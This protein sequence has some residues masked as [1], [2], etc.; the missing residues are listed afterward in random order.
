[1]SGPYALP[2][3][4]ALLC[5][6]AAARHRSFK[7]AAGELSVTPAAVSHQIRALESDLGRALFHRR[8]RGVELTEA[9][10]MLFL[11]LQ[12]SFEDISDTV[13]ALRGRPEGA[14]VSIE[15]TTAM[16]AYWL[17]PQIGAFW[18]EHPQIAISQLVSD[19]PGPGARA[20][21]AIRY[22]PP[23]RDEDRAW[24]LFHDR[25]VAVGSPGFAR[26][27]GFDR[28][29]AFGTAARSAQTDGGTPGAQAHDGIRGAQAGDR[30]RLPGDG[31]RDGDG[32]REA[33]GDRK[34]GAPTTG[35]RGPTGRA[36]G[37]GAGGKGGAGLAALSRAPLVHVVAEPRGWT[38]W[39][40]W[41]AAL[42]GPAP[43]GPRITVDNY[44]IALQMAQEDFGAALGWSGLVAPLI[45]A[46]RLVPLLPDAIP[47]PHPFHLIEHPRAP[48]EAQAFRRWL[49]ASARGRLQG[50]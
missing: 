3:M 7:I 36:P 23:P 48:R 30:L 18:K 16:S 17:T 25:I 11:G 43:N 28:G 29:G 44:M 10:A 40:D 14:E 4:T 39:S 19:A 49:V 47:S 27:H 26:A 42:G 32:E 50:G 5:F 24:I 33:R 6:E 34:T 8:H 1:M 35:D 38:G 15:A 37:P 2:S 22:G 41:F 20:D 21:L 45:E 31:D 13:A 46:G 12:R 9:G